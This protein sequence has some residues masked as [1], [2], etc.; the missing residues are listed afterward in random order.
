MT[1]PTL[2]TAVRLSCYTTNLVAYLEFDRPDA[3][4]DL[5]RS[6]RLSVRVDTP[7]G[8]LAF[9]HHARVDTGPDGWQLGYRG[10]PD[11]DRTRAALRRELDDHRRVLA[12]GNTRH[13]PWS[14]GYGGAGVPHWLLL[15]GH[16]DGRWSVVDQFAA[17]LPS[18]EQH[19]YTGWL[20]DDELRSALTPTGAV[21]AQIA[22]R[23][24]H[25]LGEPVPLPPAGHHRWLVRQPQIRAA[26]DREGWLSGPE[27]VL[28][29]LAGRLATDGAALDRHADDLWAAGRH[30]QH[31]LA[32][33]AATGR[34][35]AAV[36]DAAIR[37][38]NELPRSLRFAAASAQRGRPRPGVV[39]KA[40]DD[41]IDTMDRARR[42]ER[43]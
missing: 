27:E 20:D 32:E 34:L 37:S 11:W 13:L 23:D 38:W 43:S 18:G 3:A 1:A 22:L 31:R 2:A 7:D 25:A 26:A 4:R 28:R 42:E 8:V 33:L 30:Q 17:L 5:A 29:F 12:V 21:P 9:T 10:A 19:P 24:V 15:T 36:A 39:T 41:V 6:V 14:P 16:R 40:F 35:P